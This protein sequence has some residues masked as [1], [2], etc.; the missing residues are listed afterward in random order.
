MNFEGCLLGRL[1]VFEGLIGGF[2]NSRCRNLAHAAFDLALHK[3]H[4]GML[5]GVT[6]AQ[7]F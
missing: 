2:D 7:R 4:V 3:A 5:V 6:R 1:I